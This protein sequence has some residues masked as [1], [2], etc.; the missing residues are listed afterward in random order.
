MQRNLII[1]IPIIKKFKAILFK[2]VYIWLNFY[3]TFQPLISDGFGAKPTDLTNTHRL[4]VLNLA[5]LGRYEGGL[6]QIDQHKND[7]YICVHIRLLAVPQ[8][9]FK[10]VNVSVLE[11]G[12]KTVVV[13]RS[14]IERR[15]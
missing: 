11:T 10:T 12:Y 4:T 3:Y 13:V 15:I 5:R 6:I 14:S 9:K 7:I 2:N 8:R 1:F